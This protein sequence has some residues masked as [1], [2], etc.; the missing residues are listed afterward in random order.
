[1]VDERTQ[2][3]MELMNIKQDTMEKIKHTTEDYLGLFDAMPHEERVRDFGRYLTAESALLHIR[4]KMFGLSKDEVVE[5]IGNPVVDAVISAL[6]GFTAVGVDQG[7]M[8]P[9][10]TK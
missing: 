4:Q 10:D 6:A 2:E 3:L 9:E 1:M 8:K 7:W 5:M